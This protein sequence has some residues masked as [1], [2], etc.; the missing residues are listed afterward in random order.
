VR[1][2]EFIS[3]LGGAAAWP[4][5][6]RAQQG[7]RVRR[8]GALVLGPE[9]D[10]NMRSQWT[11]FREELTKL[12]W[13]EGR[14]LRTDFRFGSN[15]LGR[16]RSDA[17]ELV[18][19]AP[20]VIVTNGGVATRAAQERTQSIPIIFT[21]GGDPTATGLVKNVA[22]PEANTTG[23]STTEPSIAG[24]WLGVL[25]EVAPRVSRVAVVFNPEISQTGPSY[26]AS[27]ESTARTLSIEAIKTP[28]HDAVD[29]VRALDAFATTPNGGLLV[30]PPPPTSS[31]LD[32]ILR[33]AVQH[34]LPAVY[35]SGRAL[36]A[37]GGLIAYGTDVADLHRRAAAYVDRLLR[38]A[39]VADLPVQFPTKFELAVNL[40]TAKAIGLSLPP[41]LLAR[42]DEVIE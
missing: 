3:L 34:R 20:D 14:N 6:A 10:P 15:D 28:V 25:K 22:R 30:L 35:S 26:I 1:R 13:I 9:S 11:A 4:M 23:F 16:I 37:A 19:L 31:N 21:A 36:A 32:A 17:A 42:A 33:L 8:I 24:K 7:E 40:K 38:G 2:R 39:R 27:I 18:S 29:I 12:G 5:T 41:L